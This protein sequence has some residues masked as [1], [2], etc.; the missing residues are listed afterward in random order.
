MQWVKVQLRGLELFKRKG[1]L[2][3]EEFYPRSICRPSLTSCWYDCELMAS[4]RTKFLRF[5]RHN[6]TIRPPL[7][8]HDRRPSACQ[9]RHQHVVVTL[10]VIGWE[11]S[12]T[13]I[14]TSWSRSKYGDLADRWW[15][16]CH[17]YGRKFGIKM[18]CEHGEKYI[19]EKGLQILARYDSSS[20][21]V[22]FFL[23]SSSPL[24]CTFT[25][26]CYIGDYQYIKLRHLELDCIQIKYWCIC[27]GMRKIQNL[28]FVPAYWHPM[29]YWCNLDNI[30]RNT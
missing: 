9:R 18:H 23:K 29:L 25:M 2:F 4:I 22:P 1:A 21:S 16:T 11:L 20:N 13:C 26:Q 24:N 19:N 3:Q 12:C 10:C 30:I 28:Y 15:S 7:Y 6:F 17:A 27:M 14:V 8:Q 5:W